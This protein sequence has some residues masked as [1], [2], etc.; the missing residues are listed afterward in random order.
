MGKPFGEV[1]S[2]YNE[3]VFFHSGFI[4]ALI[5]NAW[6][7]IA[8][9]FF[10]PMVASVSILER[11]LFAVLFIAVL[12]IVYFITKKIFTAPK[13]T[14]IDSAEFKPVSYVWMGMFW[15]FLGALPYLSVGKYV[16][17]YGD[18]FHMRY[19]ILIPLGS[20]LIIFGLIFG[21]LK[22]GWR[23]W[24][25]S[26]L[27][28]L[29][30]TYST[31]NFFMLD[32]D[33]YRQTAIVESLKNTQ[34]EAIKKASTLVF[35]NTYSEMSYMGRGIKSGEFIIYLHEAFPNNFKS[36]LSADVGDVA[37][38]QKIED[39]IEQHY[40]RFKNYGAFPVPAD[41]NP[42]ANIVDVTTISNSNDE[43]NTV[44]KW[45]TLKKYELFSDR[46]TFLQK[47]KEKLQIEVVP[48]VPARIGE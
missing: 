11:R 12:A 7:Y 14:E 41:F 27:I 46:E 30:V 13:A 33:W 17:I 18:D 10:W 45:L 31:F 39:A 32:M 15:F 25:Y 4:P 22:E 47:L 9:G 3:F 26:I 28:S 16:T 48:M 6:S 29:F 24:A 20:A 5:D 2:G 23:P 1:G 36:A 44:R 19:G 35:H 37:P 43:N 40:N 21:A 8:Y 34:S 38:N 42:L